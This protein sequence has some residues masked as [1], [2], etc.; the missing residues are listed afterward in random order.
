LKYLNKKQCYTLLSTLKKNEEG[1][2]KE[3]KVKKYTVTLLK[4]N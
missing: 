3:K 1:E 4:K 2:K